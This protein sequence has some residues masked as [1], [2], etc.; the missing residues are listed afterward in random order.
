MLFQLTTPYFTLFFLP[1]RF[2]SDA[3]KI[4]YNFLSLLGEDFNYTFIFFF[5]GCVMYSMEDDVKNN[6]VCMA[7]FYAT[8][9][10]SNSFRRTSYEERGCSKYNIFSETVDGGRSLRI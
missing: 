9:F 10:S 3:L 8:S 1:M 7:R 6:S 2:K 4:E 5:S